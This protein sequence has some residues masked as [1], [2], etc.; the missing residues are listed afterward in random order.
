MVRGS[1]N[2]KVGGC[3]GTALGLLLVGVAVVLAGTSIRAAADWASTTGMVVEHEAVVSADFDSKTF[4]RVQFTDGEGVERTFLS[5]VGGT[6]MPPVDSEVSVSYAPDDPDQ[7]M[8][9]RARLANYGVIGGLGL[10][11]LLGAM[12]LFRRARRV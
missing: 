8:L 12:L 11:L 10:V 9:L 6:F 7:A 1:L 2:L 3:I 4:A 5:G